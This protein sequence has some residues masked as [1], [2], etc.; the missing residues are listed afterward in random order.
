M[1]D[2]APISRNGCKCQASATD[3]QAGTQPAEPK[4]RRLSAAER[5]QIANM[6][7]AG[8]SNAEIARATGRNDG[9]ITASCNANSS[10]TNPSPRP[11]ALDAVSGGAALVYCAN[12]AHEQ[13]CQRALG[14][15]T[16][17]P[18]KNEFLRGYVEEK[19]RRCG[20]RQR[21]SPAGCATSSASATS[22]TLRG[23]DLRMDLLR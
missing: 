2:T 5:D 7:A 15:R 21:G 20:G 9:T 10:P 11:A 22:A 1:Q 16:R 18:L 8:H 23:D 14:H 6:K 12:A 3:M 19:L 13:A 17:D 4:Y